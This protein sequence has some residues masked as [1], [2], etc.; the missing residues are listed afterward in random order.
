VSLGV[1]E[2]VLGLDV[3]MCNTLTMEIFNAIEDLLEATFDLAWTHS[4]A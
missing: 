1:K 3:T 2:Q 4:P